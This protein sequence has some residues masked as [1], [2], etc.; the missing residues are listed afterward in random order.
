MLPDATFDP[1]STKSNFRFRF[2]LLA[3]LVFVT[4]FCVVLAWLVQPAHVAATALFRVNSQSSSGWFFDGTPALDRAD[5]Q[6]VKKTQ[7]ALLRSTYV[8]EAAIRKPSVGGLPI[9]RT[10]GDPVKWLQENLNVEFPEQGEIMAISLRGTQSQELQ[11]VQIV[12]AIVKAYSNEV[13][14]REHQHRFAIRDLL[15][16]QFRDLKQE[17]T[18]KAEELSAIEDESGGLRG[19]KA[20]TLQELD[21]QRLDR[22]EAELMRLEGDQLRSEVNG[23][24]AEAGYLKRRI[25]QLCNQRSDLEKGILSRAEKSSEPSPRRRDLARLQRLANDMAVRLENMDLEMQSPGRVQLL[26]PATIGPAD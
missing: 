7:I 20:K 19:A 22:I 3:A 16:R 8:L 21:M 6:T 25:A 17:I 26:Q 10:R 4:I 2:S 5:F 24:E 23:T 9:L 13:L 1:G 12:D 14:E 18:R 15:A 11:L